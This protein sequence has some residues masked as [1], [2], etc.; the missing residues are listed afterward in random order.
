MKLCDLLDRIWPNPVALYFG[1]STEQGYIP[2]HRIFE[3]VFDAAEAN[4]YYPEFSI[5]EIY[6]DRNYVVI[7]LAKKNRFFKD[8][9]K[10]Q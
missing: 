6:A 4:N 1:E 10:R 9:S 8:T 5:Y 3:N 2:S 7:A